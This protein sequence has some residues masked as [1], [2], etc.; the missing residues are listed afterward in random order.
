M[1]LHLNIQEI[2]TAF[3]VLF[4][5]ID[6]TGSIP[7]FAGFN[8]SGKTVHAGKAALSS[9]AVIVLFLYVGEGLLKLFHT[10]VNSFA[11]A[12]SLILFAVAIE[13]TLDVEL[14]RN[15]APSGYTTFIPVVFP[16]IAG[17][18]TLTTTLSLRAEIHPANIIIAVVLNMAILYVVLRKIYVVEKLIG[19]GGIYVLR[20]FFGII[21]IAMAVKLFVSNIRVLLG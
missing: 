2:L 16:L 15:H 7:V 13:M 10:D 11:V 9:L 4:A 20:K 1:E 5:V 6:V 18:G 21:L 12:G 8:H 14:F 17:P 19:K 3:M